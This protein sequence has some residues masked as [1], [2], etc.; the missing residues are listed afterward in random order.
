MHRGMGCVVDSVVDDGGAFADELNIDFTCVVMVLE[1]RRNTSP[2]GTLDLHCGAESAV[3]D[4]EGLRLN[5]CNT[6]CF[7]RFGVLL[8]ICPL[9]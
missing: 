3:Q 6:D 5:A 8:G 1:K 9:N 7:A 2:I 4:I